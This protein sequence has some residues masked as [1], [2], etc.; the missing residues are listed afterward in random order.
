M[1]VLK[2]FDVG[3]TSNE[4]AIRDLEDR[5]EDIEPVDLDDIVSVN[6][7]EVVRSDHDAVNALVPDYSFEN[8][9]DTKRIDIFAERV[10]YLGLFGMGLS[11][12]SG[13][14]GRLDRLEHLDLYANSLSV[15]PVEVGNLVELWGLYMDGSG[16]SVLPSEIGS[17]VKLK[18][19][20]L[21]NNQLSVLPEELC[22]LPNLEEL[23]ISGNP[24]SDYSTVKQLRK[25]G[26]KV[27]R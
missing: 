27:Y 7:I 13:E 4:D 14:I 11:S 15:L 12:L 1:N 19:L 3:I 8:L 25:K 20:H 2:P 17:L 21:R 9:V 18:Y 6:G 16:L 5:T 26:V 22:G 23:G 24:I 10:R